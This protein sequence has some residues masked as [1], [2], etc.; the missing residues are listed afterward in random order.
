VPVLF[1]SLQLYL[2][3]CHS[4]KDKRRVIQGAAERLRNKFKCSVSELDHQ[5]LW[6][7]SRLGIAAAGSDRQ[8]LAQMSDRIREE[9]ES[10]LMGDL[11]EFTS[12][13]LE[14]Q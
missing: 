13:I 4:L 7:R 5:E 6:Q 3:Y 2:P 14:H 8:F 1:C 10:L 12:E 11:V 9:S